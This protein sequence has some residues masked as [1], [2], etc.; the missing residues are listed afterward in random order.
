MFNATMFVKGSQASFVYP[1]SKTSVPT[2]RNGIVEAVGETWVK[3]KM[4]NKETQA[5]EYK[6][7]SFAKMSK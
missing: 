4:V 3:L 2:T 7:F 1:D 6:T 5:D